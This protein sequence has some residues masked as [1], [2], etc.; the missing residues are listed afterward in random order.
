MTESETAGRQAKERRRGEG[1][2]LTR[3]TVAGGQCTACWFA[4]DDSAL[5]SSGLL[6]RLH[7]LRRVVRWR[8]D[9]RGD[10]V[11]VQVFG[12]KRNE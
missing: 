9:E 8:V 4:P 3:T 2:A 6:Y 5:E 12:R 1:K 10:L 7:T 11:G